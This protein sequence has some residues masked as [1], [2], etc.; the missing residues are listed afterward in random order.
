MRQEQRDRLTPHQILDALREGNR[1]FQSGKT[2]SR[3]YLTE[4]RTSAQGQFPAAIILGCI[5]S[6]A[7]GEIIFDTGIGDTFN[8]RI[9]GNVVN[10]DLLGSLEFAC[11]VA[12]AKVV[13]LMGHTACGAIQGA[14][15]DVELGSLTGLL[16]RIKPAVVA[17]TLTGDRS[18]R[19]AAF[20]DAVART[21][22]LMGIENI[23]DRSYVLADL[24]RNGQIK[25]LGAMYDLS[26][27]IVEF[28]E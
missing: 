9:A 10:D 20:V 21:N 2:V 12:G 4:R 19:N 24:E 5:D 15:D 17:T 23:R 27:G 25:I 22:V 11:G 8:A 14:I 3:D 28:L 1:R 7:P 16:A 26:T 6:R 13:L 18:S